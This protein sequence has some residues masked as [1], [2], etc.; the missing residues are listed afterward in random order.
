LNLINKIIV[1]VIIIIAIYAIFLIYSDLNLVKDHLGKFKIE[2]LPQIIALVVLGWFVLFYRWILLLKK[3]NIEIPKLSNFYILMSGFALSIVPG[4]IGELIKSQL[5]K[6]KY[7]IPR[8][9]T[10]PIII[11]E[12]LNNLLGIIT[13]SC[14][15]LG[16]MGLFDIE[17]FEI[18]NYVIIT[19]T[20][21]LV[22]ILIIVNSKRIFRKIFLKVSRFRFI[23]KYEL[24]VDSSY[25]ILKNSLSGKFMIVTIMLS[26]LFWII[27]GLIVYS[28]LLAFDIES[29]VFMTTITTYTSS[30]LL[31]FISFLP[32]G[33]GVTEG[34]LTG[35][36]SLQGIEI[37]LAAT[38]VVFI[39][40][41]TRWLGVGIGFIFL[42][43]SGGFSLNK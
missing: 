2:F 4:K 7:N 39:R 38:I 42:K 10:A 33:I 40:I 8:T 14:I 15:G 20:I 16:I 18:S 27:E 11:V 26:S 28:V 13:V 34:T 5:L 41:F 25:D 12:Q 31:G 1:V 43:M 3:S 9:K 21:M 6:T 32:M 36:L 24:S 29:L 17:F 30:I 37:S 19:A 23:S 22:L 35:F